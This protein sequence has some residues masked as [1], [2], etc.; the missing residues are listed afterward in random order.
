MFMA[1][2]N[3]F[4]Y[5]LS[6]LK[7]YTKILVI[8]L[9]LSIPAFAQ[10]VADVEIQKRNEMIKSLERGR[11]IKIMGD[12]YQH[13]P[14]VLAA[15]KKNAN[16]SDPQVLTDVGATDTD[17]VEKKGNFVLYKHSG[18]RNKATV[19][20]TGGT[21]T[22]PAMLNVKT[23]VIG[24]LTGTLVVYPKKMSDAE[25]IANAYGMELL[26]AF[27]QINTVY[28]RVK[29]DMDVLDV[30]AA[31]SGD[32]RVQKSYPEIIENMPVLQ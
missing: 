20:K 25:G 4:V 10:R 12:E 8:G 17:L 28:Y 2:S 14:K 9:L 21:D 19:A 13:L 11:T 23:G 27:P 26:K 15:V 1:T 31:I 24:V 22:F 16:Q 7:M 3:K 5:L 32:K 6:L 30:A 29:D 18:S